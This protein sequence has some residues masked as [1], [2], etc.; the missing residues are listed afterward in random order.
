MDLYPSFIHTYTCNHSHKAPVTKPPP[1]SP[2]RES[3]LLP[4]TK[5]G[6]EVKRVGARGGAVEMGK[7]KCR[8]AV[9]ETEITCSIKDL[10]TFAQDRVI[11]YQCREKSFSIPSV[12][13]ST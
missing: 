2:E 6:R 1:L 13:T 5:Y 11:N 9:E 7:W 4:V 8:T 10:S 12:W 3:N